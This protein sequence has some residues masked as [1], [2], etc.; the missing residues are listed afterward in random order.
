MAGETLYSG[1]CR[2]RASAKVSDG[3][4]STPESNPLAMAHVPGLAAD[5]FRANVKVPAL[6]KN[7]F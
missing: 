3:C 2:L 4:V 1:E 5:L 7:R 6:M